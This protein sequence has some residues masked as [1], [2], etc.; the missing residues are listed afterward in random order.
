MMKKNKKHKDAVEI[1]IEDVAADNE[2]NA[3]TKK[4]PHDFKAESSKKKENET[5]NTDKDDL[6]SEAE[7]IAEDVLA[8]EKLADALKEVQEWKDKYIRLHAEWDTYRRRIQEQRTEE[9]LRATEAVMNDLIP[10]LDDFERTVDYAEQNGETGLLDGV[11]AVQNKLIASLEKAGL[12]TI[13]PQGQAYEALEAQAVGTV[14]DLEA[15]DET[16]NAVLQKGYRM[17]I[18]VLRPAMVTITTGGPKR[19]SDDDKE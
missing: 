1:P 6:I 16:V 12:E 18:K 7:S 11:K 17:G 8:S 3:E 14:E 19:P 2:N 13:N 10:V 4:Q 5:L 15:Y 9:K